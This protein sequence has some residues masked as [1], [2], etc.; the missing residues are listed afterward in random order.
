M[1]GGC[2]EAR[3]C[4]YAGCK[5]HLYLDVDEGTGAIKFNFPDIEVWEMKESCS[6]DLAD[7][8]ELTL[9]EIGPMINVTRERIRQIELLTFPRLRSGMP[10]G[11]LED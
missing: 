11:V 3:P 10:D 8:G 9:D 4:P 5:H 1:P 2:N 6:L 7:R